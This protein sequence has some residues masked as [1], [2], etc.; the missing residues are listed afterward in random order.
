LPPDFDSLRVARTLFA[1]VLGI[2]VLSRAGMPR[3]V[4][5]AVRD[6]AIALFSQ[7]SD[8]EL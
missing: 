3:A 5:V 1:L 6:Q 4:I 8:G 2:R 7:K